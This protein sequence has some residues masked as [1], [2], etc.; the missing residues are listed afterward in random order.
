MLFHLESDEPLPEINAL[1]T[2][3]ASTLLTLL[4]VEGLIISWKI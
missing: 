4:N 1:F 3:A 2:F